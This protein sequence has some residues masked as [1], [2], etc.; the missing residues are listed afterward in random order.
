MVKPPHGTARRAARLA[1]LSAG[2][3]RGY[4]GYQLQRPFLAREKREQTKRS[5]RRRNARRLREELQHLR[6][7][8]MKLGQMKNYFARLNRSPSPLRPWVR[9][10]GR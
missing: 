4:L 2:M 3:L 5:L 7:P 6:G 9:S 1:Q 8:V 10:T